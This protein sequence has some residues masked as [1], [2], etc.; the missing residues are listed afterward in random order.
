MAGKLSASFFGQDGDTGDQGAIIAPLDGKSYVSGDRSMPLRRATIP[1]LFAE[2]VSRFGPREAA[3]FRQFG[4]RYT[5]YDLEREVDRFASGLLSLGIERGDRVGIWSPNRPE[6]LVTQFA[7]ARIGAIL[8]NINPAYRLAELEYALN[9][10]GCKALVTAASFKK[11]N[12]VDMINQLAPELSS[13]R[14]GALASPAVPRLKTVIRTG[15]E[16][17]PGM[18]NYDEVMRIAGPAQQLR[19]DTITRGLDPDDPINIQFTSGTTGSPKGATLT[20]YNI[21]NNARFTA[22][23]MDLTEADRLCIP[24]PLYHCFGM[25][26]GTLACVTTGSSMIFPS[27]AFEPAATLAAVSGERCTA[28]YGV[29]TMFVAML[30]HPDFRRHDYTSLRT[31]IMA[32]AP[33]PIEVMRQVIGSLH[34]PQVT[35]GYGMTETSPI[36]FQSGIDDSLDDR[37]STVGRIHPHVEVKIIDTAGNTVDAGEQ[38]ELCTRGYSVMRGYWNDE[39]RT[40]EAIDDGGWMHTGDLATIDARGYCRIVGRVK[41]MIIRGGENIYPREIEEFLYRHPKIAEVQVFGVPDAKYGEEVCAWIVA[42]PGETMTEDEV[43]AFCQGQIAHYKMPRYIRFK[44]A[45]PMTVTG[46]PQKFLMRDTM[47]EELGS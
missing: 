33:C 41:D 16:K 40:R 18:F 1:Q 20:H 12:Y 34:M 39:E 9:K 25:V 26:L 13:A 47:I 19:L 27:E 46:K 3:I 24:V 8:V 22:R 14:P 45:I 11:S 37:V 44:D 23:T 30:D 31:G 36:S 29:P 42:R 21:L 6:W 38:G 10:V 35:I 43:K 7:T 17:T 28:L 5:Y 32:G 15:P 2:T 4:K